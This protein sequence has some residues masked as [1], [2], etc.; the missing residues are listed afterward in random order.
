MVKI[1]FVNDSIYKGKVYHKRFFPF[2]HE[3]TYNLT[4]FWLDIKNI[5][6]LFFFKH[7]KFSLFSF[8]D[9]DH[10]EVGR[11]KNKSLFDYIKD[12]LKK[13]KLSDIEFI[14]VLCVPRILNY[15]FNP[16]SVFV[17]FDS[18]QIPNAIM[19]EVSNTFNERH[20]YFS[21]LNSG[22]FRSKKIF[23]V[24]P[25][26]NLDGSYEIK[27]EISF[28]QI[29]L[30]ILYKNKNK[31]LFYADF[32]GNSD[33]FNDYNLLKLFILKAFQN[34]K[35]TLGIHYEALK[36]WSKGAIYYNK[37]EKPKKFLTKLND[38]N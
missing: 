33:T 34:F 36:L 12:E 18:K 32:S 19:F 14:K 35:V 30:D 3:F 28:N 22:K 5:K 9:T 13:K 15:Q 2:E 16:I 26:F 8:F 27:F 31:K 23:H 25:F 1:N 37:P 38:E 29:K 10:G 17:C 24:S 7:N 20:S 21:S 6:N 4:Y 11:N